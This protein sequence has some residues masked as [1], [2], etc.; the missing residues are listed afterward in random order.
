MKKKVYK[1]FVRHNGETVLVSVFYGEGD[2]CMFC[3][4]MNEKEERAGSEAYYFIERR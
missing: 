4:F 3:H 2:A 1:V